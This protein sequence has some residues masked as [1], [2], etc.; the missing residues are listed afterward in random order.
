MKTTDRRERSERIDENTRIKITTWESITRAMPNGY[1]ISFFM[2][3]VL[4]SFCRLCLDWFS[5]PTSLATT[6]FAVQRKSW[7]RSS[8][9]QFLLFVWANFFAPH[10]ST[11]ASM[12]VNE[13]DKYV[14]C[15]FVQ[16]STGTHTHSPFI[17][18]ANLLTKQHKIL[19][20]AGVQKRTLAK[21]CCQIDRQNTKLHFVHAKCSIHL[22]CWEA[23]WNSVVVCQT[24]VNRHLGDT[25]GLRSTALHFSAEQRFC[26][27]V[28]HLPSCFE[29]AFDNNVNVNR[30][31]TSDEAVNCN[32]VRRRCHG[33]HAQI[34]D[35]FSATR[36]G[37]SDDS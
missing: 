25:N 13:V 24:N 30:L 26:R 12:S 4:T 19:K 5:T 16:P 37:I 22:V 32:C 31:A 17:V 27:H 11:A 14:L 28:R 35:W 2:S 9:H 3:F 18:D 33:S 21:A 10:H 6:V 29:C 34:F 20:I 23:N 8:V 1:R 7:L 36:N 15:L